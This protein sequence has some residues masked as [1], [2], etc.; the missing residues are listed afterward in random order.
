MNR[1]KLNAGDLV[2]IRLDRYRESYGP[3]WALIIEKRSDFYLVM[4]G[5]GGKPWKIKRKTL[6]RLGEESIHAS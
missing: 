1:D 3:L 2:D 4:T 6:E 5:D